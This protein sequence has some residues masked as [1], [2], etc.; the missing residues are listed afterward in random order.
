MIDAAADIELP[1]EVLK[2]TQHLEQQKYED[3]HR[4]YDVVRKENE[5]LKARLE[6]SERDTH[7]FVSYFQRE[8]ETKDVRIHSLNEVIAQQ[9][10]ERKQEHEALKKQHRE[11]L[12]ALESQLANSE[13]SLTTRVKTLE[14]E[15]A[16]VESFREMKRSMEQK[17]E[18]LEV[19]VKHSDEKLMAESTANERKYLAEK[20]KMQKELERRTSE[21]RRQAKQEM[22][23]GLDADT[24]KVI[25]DN[26]R[27]AEELRFQQ[28]MTTELQD[29]K[30]RVE[31]E[32]KVVRR[33]LELATQKE[34]EYARQAHSRKREIAKLEAKVEELNALLREA[35]VKFQADKVNL[36]KGLQAN[37]EEQTLD[38]AGLRQMLR[39]KNREL[40][41]LQRLAKLVLE[42]RTE[43]EQFFLDSLADV[44]AQIRLKRQAQYRSDVADYR[45]KIRQATLEPG[46]ATFP[47][48]RALQAGKPVDTSVPNTTLP[49]AA[50]SKVYLK[51]LTLEDREHVL[52]LL[53]AKINAVHS[54]GDR[55]PN[56]PPHELERDRTFVTTSAPTSFEAA[57]AAAAASIP[58]RHLPD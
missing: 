28:Q 13:S 20:S 4:R 15:L 43:V 56:V 3:L 19:Q 37:L 35:R 39:L 54:G 36:R 11:Q 8:L 42:Q 24:L 38:A 5:L 26:R 27:M 47:K 32:L 25:A 21:I 22:Q 53:F 41:Q 33:D 9:D 30:K 40:R 10:L 46:A 12:S 31:G 49:Q 58:P 45:A 34:G 16:K 18:S 7:E 6:K 57:A 44:K 52:R 14:D 23:N 51:D 48:I 1:P 29:E 17:I 55:S 2:L 50:G